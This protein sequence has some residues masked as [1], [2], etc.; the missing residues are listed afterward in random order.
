MATAQRNSQRSTGPVDKTHENFHS[1]RRR[2]WKR[3]NGNTEKTTCGKS[4]LPLAT[5]QTRTRPT[6][7]PIWPSR[8]MVV[9]S[10]L[11]S[12]WRTHHHHVP[13]CLRL[14]FF[15]LSFAPAVFF[16]PHLLPL[17]LP[18]LLNTPPHQA[19]PSLLSVL[20]LNPCGALSARV[21]LIM[22]SSFLSIA[23][24]VLA[25]TSKPTASAS[26][27]RRFCYG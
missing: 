13:C 23:T 24:G 22:V 14:V 18:P 8:V 15:L 3:N 1:H 10:Y 19:S 11:L 25:S 7:W 5:T 16:A 20:G 26:S 4:I 12:T 17:P 6:I 9:A 21:S 2:K 27:L